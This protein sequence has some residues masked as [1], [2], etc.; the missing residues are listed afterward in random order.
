MTAIPA[1]DLID[2]RCV[3]LTEGDFDTVK[4]YGEDPVEVARSFA[5][6][7]AERLH[8]VDLDAARGTGGNRESIKAIRKA[9]PGVLDVGGGIRSI[10]EARSLKSLG[11]DFLIVGTAL[12]KK[13]DDVAAWADELGSVFVAGID[14]RDGEVKVSGWE[15][16]STIP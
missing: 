1:I 8:V 12:V 14:A 10:E 13:P 9:F 11:V 4:V 15:D 5:A 2:G 6:S 7:G 3:R 16:G